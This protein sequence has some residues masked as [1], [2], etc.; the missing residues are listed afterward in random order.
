MTKNIILAILLLCNNIQAQFIKI[1]DLST[2]LPISHASIRCEKNKMGVLSNEFGCFVLPCSDKNGKIIVQCLGYYSDTFLIEKLQKII[3]LKT[4]LTEL[5]EVEVSI[6]YAVL[7]L[8]KAKIKLNRQRN[9]MFFATSYIRSYAYS[10]AEPSQFNEAV[11]EVK[12]NSSGIW[13]YRFDKGR[14]ALLKGF[15][16]KINIDS[17]IFRV[18]LLHIHNPW[19]NNPVGIFFDSINSKKNIKI[20]KYINQKGKNL[21]EITLQISSKETHLLWINVAD[22]SIYKYQII[23][24]FKAK[25]FKANYI[26]LRNLSID[27]NPIND[28]TTLFK[29]IHLSQS[30]T[31]SGTFFPTKVT[32]ELTIDI[33]FD[34]FTKHN[35]SN[36]KKEKENIEIEYLHKKMDKMPLDSAFWNKNL[37]LNNVGYNQKFMKLLS[38]KKTKGNFTLNDYKLQKDD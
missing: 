10:N 33:Y 6:N 4:N 12:M 27:F 30:M 5:Q 31:I 22:F 15:L 23:T 28:S 1:I 36:F 20:T 29:S 16:N 9:E 19:W 18:G 21:A 13:D 26:S 17:D 3:S 7:L 32:N 34:D 37:V 25:E 14:Y 2:G 11:F 38:R 35:R 8:N 24:Y